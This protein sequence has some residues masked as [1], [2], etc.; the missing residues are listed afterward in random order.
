MRERTERPEAVAA[1]VARLVGSDTEAIVDEASRL[2]A[3]AEHYRQMAQPASPYG[4]GHAGTRIAA[5]VVQALA[6]P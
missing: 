6:A 2:L 5:R 4:D 1:G 3:D